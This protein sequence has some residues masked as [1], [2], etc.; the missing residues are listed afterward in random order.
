ML[1]II[2]KLRAGVKKSFFKY[3]LI[4]CGI[5]SLSL[6]L[7]SLIFILA[8]AAGSLAVTFLDVGQG[9]SVLIKTPTDRIIL[10]DGGP[11]NKILRRLGDFLPFYRRQ[12]DYLIFSHY[13]DD[14]ITGLIEII[15][16]YKV[17]HLI[18][19][20]SDYRSPVLEELL[21]VIKAQDIPTTILT[22]RQQLFFS[23]ACSLDLLNPRVLG[24]KKNENN[25]LIANLNCQGQKFLLAG[26]NSSQVE[27]AL[28]ASSL[29]LTANILKA[30]HHGSK[31]ANSFRFLEVVRPAWLIISV[32]ADN[33]FR[34][35][36]S[37][38]LVRA[39]QLGINVK[40]TDQA[41]S[42]QLIIPPLKVH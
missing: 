40:R 19:A 23:A 21:A 39:A 41:G 7:F 37:D 13:H 2:Q 31:S 10:I 42:I 5:L 35:P 28:L 22:S 6:V 34:H 26:D 12:L 30:S 15:R 36:D 25:S 14:H 3:F 24:V 29:N 32:G 20:P 8:S 38:L 4:F 16:R 11:D 27:Q 9:D 17:K 1:L 18:Y 33:K